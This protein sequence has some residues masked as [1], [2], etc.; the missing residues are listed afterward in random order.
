MEMKVENDEFWILENK[1]A[2]EK[3]V[4]N[5]LDDSIKHIKKYLKNK[6]GTDLD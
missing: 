3:T 1:K 5:E 4:F 2:D 6:A